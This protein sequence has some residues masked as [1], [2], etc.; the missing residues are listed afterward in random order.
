MKSSKFNLTLALACVALAFSLAVCAQAQTVTFL[1]QFTGNQGSAR[2][3]VQ[4]TD[5]NFYGAADGGVYDQGQIF[6]MTPD[7]EITTIYSFCAQ[8]G[9][10]DGS[11]LD[12]G[13]ILGS[14]GNLYGVTEG[15]TGASGTFYKMTLDGE[16]TTLY[17]FCPNAG[18]ADGQA[19]RGV[20]LA[21]D[22]N[23]YGVTEIGGKFSEGTIFSISPTGKF[24]L[25]HTFC[26]QS[27]C[28]DGANPTYP[29]VQ[30]ID[31]NFYGTAYDGGTHNGGVIY[32]ITAAGAFK[33]LYNFSG[34]QTSC[35][36]GFLPVAILQDS[37]GNLFGTTAG[38][39]TKN[40]GTVF[41]FT[42]KNQYK[43]V[44]SFQGYDGEQP[45]SGL[46]L[47]NNGSL[48][49]TT[50][51]GG[52]PAA[53]NI[54]KVTSAGV[55]K[56]IYVFRGDVGYDPAYALFQS[57]NGLFYGTTA[58]GPFPCC[59]GMIFSLSDGQKP[60]VET[61]PVAGKVGKT[62]LILGNN[63]TGTTS[64]KFNGVAAAFT[65]KSDTYIQATVPA[66]ATTGKVSV[67]TPSGTLNSNPQF[68]VTK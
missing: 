9:C 6:R 34:C 4:G 24:K 18:C 5:G 64:V 50:E 62:V 54:Y 43:V 2:T 31:G 48:Y 1:T 44:H 20:I 58:Y 32:Q 59:Y 55:F 16:I 51:G 41:E 23:F 29:P 7:G 8:T 47:A 26:S 38:G 61:V 14:E 22:G 15:G 17:T 27:N 21:S 13:P 65:V 10:P 49:G 30:G 66:G 57:T 63:L 67:V 46:T 25:L 19:P 11:F 53:G 12:R 33:V 39:G 56:S 60:S 3:V 37:A 45:T 35:P 28:T 52:G 36:T 42:S 40:D 68:V